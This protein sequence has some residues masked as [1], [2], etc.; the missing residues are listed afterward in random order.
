M[1]RN[2]ETR[3]P[4]SRPEGGDARESAERRAPVAGLPSGPPPE[5]P[6]E[7]PQRADSLP[8]RRP[9]PPALPPT[10][11]PAVAQHQ[12]LA[13]AH[14]HAAPTRPP[15]PPVVSTDQNKVHVGRAHYFRQLGTLIQIMRGSYLLTRI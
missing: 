2:P 15:D 10:P 5:R 13:R 11:G 9:P 6:S 3:L 8:P 1:S 14:S 12:R 4:P 7:R